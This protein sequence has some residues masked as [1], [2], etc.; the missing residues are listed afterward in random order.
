MVK[1]DKERKRE[2]GF[3]FLN[4]LFSSLSFFVCLF[5]LYLCSYIVCNNN[6]PTKHLLLDF[7]HSFRR[8]SDGIQ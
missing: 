1:I 7:W 5:R 4:L 2:R 3:R 8:F 6:Y